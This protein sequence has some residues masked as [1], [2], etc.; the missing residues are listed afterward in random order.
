MSSQEKKNLK[1]S[2]P[3]NVLKELKKPLGKLVLD[4]DITERKL[5]KEKGK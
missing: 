3:P 4:R 5:R 2:I 1:V